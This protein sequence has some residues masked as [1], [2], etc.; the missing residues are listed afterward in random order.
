MIAFDSNVLVRHYLTDPDEPKQSE[1]AR[2]LVGNALAKGYTVYLSQIV[3]CESV[4]V[5]ERCY[6]ISRKARIKFL[7]SVLHDPP[8]QV[9]SPDQV[10][11]AL[12]QFTE[13]KADFAD[14]LIAANA[15]ANGCKK[16]LTFDKKAK[17]ISGMKAVT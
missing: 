12:R 4:W 3:L 5:F 17:A 8:F 7:Q 6:N 9:E 2:R 15:K 14:C 1:K 10:T 16:T 13:T 11:K